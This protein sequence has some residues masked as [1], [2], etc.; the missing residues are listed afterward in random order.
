[1]EHIQTALAEASEEGETFWW[2][3]VALGI[4][5]VFLFTPHLSPADTH[6]H[7]PGQGQN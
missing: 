5:G 3:S 4:L 6:I 2:L 1:M 7:L